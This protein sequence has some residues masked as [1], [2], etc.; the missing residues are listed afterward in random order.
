[1]Q[2]K[3]EEFLDELNEEAKLRLYVRKAIQVI[4]E[5]KKTQKKQRLNEQKALRSL[6]KKLVSEA[7]VSDPEE[8]P[9]Q[10]TGINVLEGLLKKII[11]IL[12]DEFKKLTTSKEQRLSFRAHVLN[13][14]KDTLAPPRVTDK[15]DTDKSKMVSISEQDSLDITIGDT[16]GKPGEFIDIEPSA[17]KSDKDLEKDKFSLEGEDETGRDMAYDTFK[18][19]ETNIVDAWDILYADEDKELFYDYLIT[20]LKLY[21]DKFEDEL[22]VTLPEPTTPEYEEEVSAAEAEN[23]GA[24][25][26]LGTPEEEMPL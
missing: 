14:V 1:M 11:P 22:Q 24:E 17:P 20:N 10:S 18:R 9:H 23:M 26:E 21:F 5:R 25:G 7:A 16:D 19:I 4:S 8:S 2:I 15:A 3:R 12:E 6:V 13:A